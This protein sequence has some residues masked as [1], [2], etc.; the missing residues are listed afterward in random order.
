MTTREMIMAP[1]AKNNDPEL[2]LNVIP[3]SR[4]MRNKDGVMIAPMPLRF[5]GCPDSLTTDGNLG[6]SEISF[7][8]RISEHS[9]W[10]ETKLPK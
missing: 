9:E 3:I 1:Q 7:L 6:F 8:K 4:Q 10:R 5:G 2:L